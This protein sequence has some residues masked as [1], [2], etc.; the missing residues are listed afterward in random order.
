[1]IFGGLPV[2]SA[3]AIGSGMAYQRFRTGEVIDANVPAGFALV[4]AA[5]DRQNVSVRFDEC[6]THKLWPDRRV[7]L[8]L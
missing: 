5:A 7:E 1:M 3:A 6:D 2:G 4:V 8:R